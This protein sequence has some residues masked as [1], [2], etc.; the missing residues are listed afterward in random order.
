MKNKPEETVNKVVN[1]DIDLQQEAWRRSIPAQVFLNYFLGIN[2]YIQHHDEAGLQQLTFFQQHQA[3]LNKSDLEVIR[4]MLISSW[5]TEYALRATA[6][7][8][9]EEYLRHALHWSFPQAFYTVFA[10]LQAFLYTL[11]IKTNHADVVSREVGR[12]VIRRAYPEAVSYFA[13]G[14]YPNFNAHRLAFG[15]YKPGL[16][17]PEKDVDAQAQIG[18]FLRTSRKL[19]ALAIR[20]KLQANSQTALRS[21]KTGKILEKW[22]S[23]HWQEISWR[24]GY[25]TFFDLLSR[26]RISASNKEIERFVEAEVDFKQFHQSLLSIASYLNGL[27]EAYVAKAMG[28]AQYQDLVASLPIH[29]QQGFVAER[30]QHQIVPLLD[31]NTE[32]Q[33][34]TAA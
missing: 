32:N 10:S 29:L 20:Q 15:H 23:S 14:S 31:K 18:Q 5:S 21:T 4:K 24:L 12:L 26:L 33:I 22:N 2:H 25:T 30:L 9:D 1:E 17:A 7:L 3:N 11:G 28:L 8:G 16:H 19:K 6:E 27:H 13:A 34:N